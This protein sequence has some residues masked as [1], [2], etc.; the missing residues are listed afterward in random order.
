MSFSV[1]RDRVQLE[2]PLIIPDEPACQHEIA[3]TSSRV[4]RGRL[5]AGLNVRS[6]ALYERCVSD[7]H[8][9]ALWWAPSKNGGRGISRMRVTPDLH[10]G[11]FDVVERPAG[12]RQRPRYSRS[13]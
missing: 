6:R 9:P 10:V 4:Q 7:E 13:L 3:P 1:R 11:H 12:N 8:L 2:R 5:I